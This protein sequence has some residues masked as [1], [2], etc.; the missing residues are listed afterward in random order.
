MKIKVIGT[1]LFLLATVPW[2]VLPFQ[3]AL[4][5]AAATYLYCGLLMNLATHFE[6]RVFRVFVLWYPATIL[7]KADWLLK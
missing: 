4:P 2:C 5:C 1:A 3:W 6:E 7:D